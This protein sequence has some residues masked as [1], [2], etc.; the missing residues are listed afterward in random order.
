VTSYHKIRFTSG[1][2][3]KYLELIG[4]LVYRSRLPLSNFRYL[5]LDNHQAQLPVEPAVDDSD[6]IEIHTDSYWGGA[7]LDFVLRFDFHV[8]ETWDA[9]PALALFLPIGIA[10]D[11]SHP[12]ALVY[13][14]GSLYAACDRHH[15]EII[16]PSGLNDGRTHHVS[17]HG[18]TGSLGDGKAGALWMGEPALVQIHQPTRDFI[19][20]A[21]VALGIANNLNEDDPSR[22]HLYHAL[23]ESFKLLDTRQPFEDGFYESVPHAHHVLQQGVELAGPALDVNITAAG[24][25]H[26]DVAWLWPLS[27]TRR[28]VGRTFHNILRLMEQFPDFCF[29]QS[30]AQ[31]YEYVRQDYPALF[32]SI[33]HQIEAGRWEVI[34]GMWVEADCNISGGEALARQFLLGNRFFREYFGDKAS[35]RVLW[36]PD[37]FG[38]PYSLPQLASEA[39]LKYFFTIKMGWSQ[40]NR[41]PYDSFLWQGLDGTRLLAHFSPTK[42][43][44]AAFVS[45]YNARATPYEALSTWRNFLQKDWGQT[46]HTPPL[47]MVYGHGDGGGGPTREM[48]E[49]IR[50]MGDF[51]ATP[52]VRSGMV[53]DFFERLESEMGDHLPVWNGEL[54]LEYHRGTYTTQ[55]RNKRANRKSEFLLHDAEF[56]ASM[57]GILEKEFEYTHDLLQRAWQMLCLNQFHDILPGSSIGEVYQESLEQY[58]EVYQIGEQVRSDALSTIARF[59]GGDLLVVNPTSFDRSDLAYWVGD[60]PPNVV[61]RR[62]DGTVVS[63]QP[64]EGGFLLDTGELPAYSVTP[65]SMDKEVYDRDNHQTASGSMSVSDVHLENDFLRV[66]FNREGDIKRIHDKQANSEVLPSGTLANQMQ[67][68][69]DRPR[70]PD[71]WEIDVYYEDKMWL[72]EAAD[73]IRVVET[74]PL[75]IVVEIKRRVLNSLVTQRISLAY[76]SARLD[77]DTHVD[78]RE[79]HI[80]LKSAFPVEV[81]SPYATYDIQWGSVQ[82]P[83]HRNTSWDWAKFEVP[84]HKWVDLSEGGYGVSLLNDCKYGYDVHENVMRLSLLRGPTYPHPEADLGEQQF[85]YSLLP[86]EGS[87]LRPTITEAYALNDPLFVWRAKDAGDANHLLTGSL[88]SVDRTNIVVETIKFAEDGRGLVVRLYE[89]QAWRGEFTLT[90]G[91]KIDQAWRTNLLEQ[92]QHELPFE[93]NYLQ[94]TIKPYQI[95][96]L[97]ILPV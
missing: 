77:F 53:G 64:V 74:G 67:A 16:L 20:L 29:V 44:N 39:G 73:S 2:I 8:P 75:R 62:S 45:T 63:Y 90:T 48:L 79:R 25:A 59:V 28:K 33:I 1:K 95:L 52:R 40:Y 69:E 7:G 61:L 18:W 71:A 84:A 31:L 42:E 66:E 11:F 80:L 96:T 5:E 89:N 41:L 55:A 46:G 85:V 65:L 38:F 10:G 9:E 27:Q 87:S 68:F 12:E 32:Q 47:L 72:A 60:L 17:L 56:L 22:A 24:H 58:D 93:Q 94:G 57:A 21:R 91:F 76:N 13:I 35:T 92:D 23:N 26:I 15:Q 19:S 54:Y 49:N 51:P 97:R 86:H 43:S 37:V 81:L 70:T 14:D 4:A 34:G 78:W 36:L 83:T 88:V 6:W 30:Q 82:R 50:L 3:K